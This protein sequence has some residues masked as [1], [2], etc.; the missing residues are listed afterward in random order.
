MGDDFI[1]NADGS[2]E[3]KHHIEATERAG[4]TCGMLVTEV[5]R[6]RVNQYGVLE[7]EDGFFKSI[8][9]KP[10]PSKAPSNLI[11]ISKYIFD[12]TIFR[13]AEEL[14]AQP[15]NGE[16][17]ITDVLNTYVSHGNKIAVVPA[18]GEYLDG[19]TLEGWL[20]ANNRVVGL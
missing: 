2:S 17:H 19:G 14:V 13:L 20:Q 9:E 18:R 3:A 6:E 11:N 15:R 1:Y 4:G 16:Y 7:L 12:K 5:P 8:V 10:E